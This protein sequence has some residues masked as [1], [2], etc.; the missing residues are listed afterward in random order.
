MINFLP[1]SNIRFGVKI[2]HRHANNLQIG[3][4]QEQILYICVLC[5]DRKLSVSVIMV[6]SSKVSFSFLLN[7]IIE[8]CI[9]D[10]L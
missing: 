1:L 8:I 7:S 4:S 6:T 3:N 2:T 5:A 10:S 9:K